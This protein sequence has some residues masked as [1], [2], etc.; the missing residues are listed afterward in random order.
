MG[1]SYRVGGRRMGSLT[2]HR[3]QPILW[4]CHLYPVTAEEKFK[5]HFYF[6]NRQ[7]DVIQ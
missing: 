7:L 6:S 3:S 2:G 4:I 5:G 1:S